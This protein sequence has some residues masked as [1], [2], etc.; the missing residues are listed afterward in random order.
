VKTARSAGVDPGDGWQ[1]IG[2]FVIDQLDIGRTAAA[3]LS[4]IRKEELA[5]LERD[6]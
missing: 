5:V 3:V 4:G 2:A 6:L 1:D